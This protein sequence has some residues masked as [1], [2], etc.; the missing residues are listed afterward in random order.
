M[1]GEP[2]LRLE[3]IPGLLAVRDTGARPANRPPHCCAASA[4]ST[5]R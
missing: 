2:G 5:P 4:T 1:M 3:Q